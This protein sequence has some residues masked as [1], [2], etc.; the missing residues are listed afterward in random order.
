V[1][2][3]SE[4]IKAYEL[5][6]EVFNVISVISL[7]RFRRAK[8]SVI[9]KLPYF[10][11]LEE[12]LEHLYVLLP[13]HP[14]F[15]ERKARKAL[16]VFL[17]DLSFTRGLCGKL[18]KRLEGFGAKE[19]IAVGSKCV[20]KDATNVVEGVF[21]KVFLESELVRLFGKLF[22]RY[23]RG[24]LGSVWV[25]YA[26]PLLGSSFVERSYSPP[27]AVISQKEERRERFYS[28]A[29]LGGAG[30]VS[31]G[32]AGSWEPRL[33]RF[34]PPSVRGRYRGDEVLNTEVPEEVLLGEVM[35]LYVQLG[36][37]FLGFEH[38]T[39]LNLY[40]FRSAKRMRDNVLRALKRLRVLLNK[41]RQERINRELQDIV[42]ALLAFEEER[43][44]DLKQEGFVLEVGS[45]VEPRLREF[46]IGEVRK[47]VSVREVRVV[48]GLLGFRLVSQNEVYDFSLEHYLE[49]L[50][51]SLLSGV[52]SLRA[53]SR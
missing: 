46:L 4:K 7:N 6:G 32:E 10:R 25:L 23:E 35:R 49:E 5:L 24:E 36:A 29:S 14:L 41:E 8:P 11:R 39:A 13:S 27:K 3:L 42:F 37:P 52:L 15:R 43:F 40:R 44:R 1:R 30:A 22:E 9:R 19:L 50:K 18:L 47:R 20:P 31:L 12:V 21:G 53:P 28:G 16:V 48:E 17:S 34:L 45:V 38:Y 26:S 51:R 2:K 33:V